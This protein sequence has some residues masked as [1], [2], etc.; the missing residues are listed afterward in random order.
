MTWTTWL[1]RADVRD[2]DAARGSRFSHADHALEAAVDGAGIV[3]GRLTLA[4]RDLRAGRL[5]AP[6]DLVLPSNASFYFCCLPETA[7]APKVV[8]FRNFVRAEI[9]AERSQIEIW[10]GKPGPAK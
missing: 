10:R 6:F 1:T 3:L 7:E 2:V 8:A 5:V 9:K 4:A